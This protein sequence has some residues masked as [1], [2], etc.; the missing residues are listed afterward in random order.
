[1]SALSPAAIAI[2]AKLAVRPVHV[3]RMTGEPM[4]V[5]D[6]ALD[7]EAAMIAGVADLARR[8]AA[9]EVVFRNGGWSAPAGGSF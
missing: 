2:R 5:S 1:M 3:N 9:G 8:R 6:S 7:F 4:L